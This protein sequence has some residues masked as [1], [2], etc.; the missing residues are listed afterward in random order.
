[1][2]NIIRY[3]VVLLIGLSQ[4]ILGNILVFELTK[5]GSIEWNVLPR[6]KYFWII[7]L[8]IVISVII[9]IFD[10]RGIKE[11]KNRIREKTISSLIESGIFETIFS[12]LKQAVIDGNMERFDNLATFKSKLGVFEK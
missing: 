8:L 1:M 7:I 2:K 5:S 4:G 9:F 12:E 11:S 3:V 6:M 10:S